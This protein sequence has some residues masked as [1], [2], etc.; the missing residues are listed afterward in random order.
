[1]REYTVVRGDSF[2]KIARAHNTTTRAI[3]EANPNI[4]PARLQIGA[5]IKIPPADTSSTATSSGASG[6]PVSNGYVYTVISGDTLTRIAQQH[7]TTV[8]A[9]RAANGLRTSRLLVGQKL[10]I[11]SNG[12]NGNGGS[13]APRF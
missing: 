12:T 6:A 11:P 3:T 7:G 5:K 9:L 4:D 8:S 13:T 2:Y 10:T 1:M